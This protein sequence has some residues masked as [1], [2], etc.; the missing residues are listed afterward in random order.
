MAKS[1]TADA[2]TFD[3]QAFLDS[4]A[5]GMPLAALLDDLHDVFFFAK[6]AAG[7]FVLCNPA[8][9]AMS[10]VDTPDEVYGKTDHDFFP[11]ALAERYVDD[12]EAVL[13]GETI[14]ARIEMVLHTDRTIGWNLTSKIALK[15]TA[16]EIVG[17]AGVSRDFEKLHWENPTF[18]ALAQ[19]VEHVRHNFDQSITIPSLAELTGLSASQF[20]RN[21]QRYFQMRPLQF[22]NRVRLAAACDALACTRQPIGDIAVG[23]GFYDH[24]HF[25]RLFTR[26][27]GMSPRRYR[28]RYRTRSKAGS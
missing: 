24:S 1:T 4:V 10:G 15:N 7:R 23:A 18:Q 27:M 25:T 8:F 26:T 17:T 22:I 9:A 28:N 21:F 2:P 14:S 20:R 11:K 6:D 5:S 3:R 16:G 12:D 19:V 13:N